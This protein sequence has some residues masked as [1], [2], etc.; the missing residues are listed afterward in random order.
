VHDRSF[1][2]LNQVSGVV[3]IGANEGQERTLYQQLGLSVIWIEPNPEVYEKLQSNLI[4]FRDQKA[5]QYLVADCDDKEFDFHI[6]NNNGESSSIMKF[7]LHKELWPDVHYTRTIKLFSNTLHS[8]YRLE[9]IEES[10]YKALILDTQGS[11]LLVL[12]G[13]CEL[14]KSFKYIKCEAANFESYEG[15]C[16]ETDISMYLR[17]KGFEQ[18]SR[19]PFAQGKDGKAYFNIVYQNVTKA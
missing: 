18:V 2:F 5:Y 8:I 15:C 3:H 13:A 1:K 17:S 10:K 12:R 11:E 19:T 16:T 7:A 14:L 4:G 6:S 9:N